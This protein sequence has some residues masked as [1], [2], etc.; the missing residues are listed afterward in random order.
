RLQ[1]AGYISQIITQAADRLHTKA[2]CTDVVEVHGSVLAARCD[3][4]GERYGLPEVGAFMADSADGV[5]R[6]TTPGCGYPLRPAGTLWGEPLQE[7]GVQDAWDLA[8][9]AEVFLVFDSALRTIPISLLPSVPLTRNTPLGIVGRT[10][11]QYDR[12]ARVVV[13]SPGEPVVS[14]LAELLCRD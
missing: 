2:G 10:P 13:R 6:C 8:A 3:R 11:T 12:Y 1:R 9:Q 4:C 7:R 14:A 5:P